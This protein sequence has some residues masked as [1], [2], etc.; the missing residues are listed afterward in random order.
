MNTISNSLV[1]TQKKAA[2][3]QETTTRRGANVRSNPAMQVDEQL[4]WLFSFCLHASSAKS[5]HGLRSCRKRQEKV[6]ATGTR[7]F[8]N[9]ALHLMRFLCNPSVTPSHKIVVLESDSH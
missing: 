7:K 2:V 3:V 4:C 5:D 9:C 8:K 6:S 1:L